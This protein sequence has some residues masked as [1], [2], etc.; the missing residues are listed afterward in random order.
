V[1]VDIVLRVRYV[2]FETVEGHDHLALA[3]EAP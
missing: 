3:G 2:R 1:P